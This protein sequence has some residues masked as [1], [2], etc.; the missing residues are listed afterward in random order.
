LPNPEQALSKAIIAKAKEVYEC[1][2]SP[3]SDIL[4]IELENMIWNAFGLVVEEVT[5]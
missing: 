1:I 5:G 3:K 4:Q 2:P